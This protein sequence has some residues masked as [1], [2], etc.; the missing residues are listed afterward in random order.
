MYNNT[1]NSPEITATPGVKPGEKYVVTSDAIMDKIDKWYIRQISDI[2]NDNVFI[3]LS[4][5]IYLYEKYLRVTLQMDEDESF[6]EGH[7]AFN[8]MRI[9]FDVDPKIAYKFWQTWRNGLLHRANPKPDEEFE[10]SMSFGYEKTFEIKGKEIKF[11]P[12]LI[13]DKVIELIKSR[14]IWKDGDYKIMNILTPI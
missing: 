3:I 11:N 1:T 4:A 9:D 7:R 12:K 2:N 6:S 13:K 10:Y 8:Q 14:R 5:C